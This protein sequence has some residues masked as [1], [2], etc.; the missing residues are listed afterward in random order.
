LEAT[1]YEIAY[2]R[3]PSVEGYDT[4][5]GRASNRRGGSVQFAVVIDLDGPYEGHGET[6]RGGSPQPPVVRGVDG[7]GAMYVLGNAYWVVQPQTPYRL[8]YVRDVGRT[9]VATKG[10]DKVA[11]RVRDAIQDEFGAPY[12]GYL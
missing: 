3:V 6:P 4:I 2:R 1:G 11:V 8:T 5:A 12:R 9:W 10:A 7:P